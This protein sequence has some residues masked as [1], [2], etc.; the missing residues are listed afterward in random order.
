MTPEEAIQVA[1][2]LSLA[3]AGSQMT[4]IQRMILR[5][6]LEN[7][8]YDSMAD[9]AHIARQHIKNEGSQLWKL[10][11]EALGE[12]VS[13]KNFK[14]LLERRLR[15]GSILP[16]PPTSSTYN[17]QTWVGRES[18]INNLLPE[19][20]EQTRLLWITGISGIGKT[21]LGECLASQAWE[22]DPSFQ[23]IYLE[24][25]EGQSRDFPSIA[26]DLLG[27]LGDIELAP[28]ER[29]DPKRLCDRL[30]RKLQNNHYWVQLD[31]LERLINPDQPTEF[32]D[33]YWATFFRRCLTE[34]NF[35]SRLVLTAQA[36][37]TVLLSFCDDYAN[38]WQ[39]I[40]VNGLPKE[41]RLEFFAKRGVIVEDS[42]RE[43]LTRIAEIYEGHPL[44]LKVIAEDILKEFAGD[45]LNYWQENQ[46]EFEQVARE[47]QDARLD[48]TE[49]NEAL[50]R[51]VRERIR[52]S[53]EQLPGDALDLLCRSSVFRRPVPKQFW[54]AMISDRTPQQQKAAYRCLGD[55]ALVEQEGIHQNQHLIRQHNLIR[56]ITYDFLQQNSTT[57]ETAERRA[58]DQWLM[59]YQPPC[60]G[61]NLEKVR[62][63]LEAFDHLLAVQDWKQA[64][65]LAWTQI[66]TPTKEYLCCQ[67]GT[68]GYYREQIQLYIKLSK[69]YYQISDRQ[70]ESCTLGNLGVAFKNLGNSEQAIEHY[71]QSLVIDR[72]IN[73]QYGEAANLANLGNV[74]HILGKNQMAI[75]FQQQCLSIALGISDRVMEGNVLGSLG[76]AYGELHQHLYALTYHEQHLAITREMGDRQGEANALGSL[77]N[78]YYFLGKAQQAIT[79]HQQRLAIS[80]KIGDRRGEGNALSSLGMC[81]GELS[82]HLEAIDYHQ[83]HL[84]IAR[85]VGDQQGEGNALGNLGSMWAALER[86]A[87]AIEISQLAAKIFNAIGSWVSEAQICEHLAELYQYVGLIDLAQ[88]YCSRALILSTELDIPLKEECQRLATELEKKPED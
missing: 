10:L 2:E 46:R 58:A 45:V 28:M 62:G 13:K 82:Q 19:L 71:Q 55:R 54:L 74:Y 59:V 17:E 75:E 80:R 85:E 79:Y 11:A 78:T 37:P 63:Y 88:L 72:E 31:S 77:G 1:D 12:K 33:S 87:E 70:G 61:S 47:L 30:L 86:Y 32:L 56:D 22:S 9:E 8:T 39:Q 41:S 49:Y 44:V 68:W 5:E 60:N 35:I 4:D 52:Q 23:W 43:I 69:L 15:S 66:D 36:L 84:Q 76:L 40:Q 51:R 48:E 57:W 50:D 25:L 21:A 24:I 53:L 34:A 7:K 83:Q 6:S 29:N 14:G 67:L 73:N 81:C 18:L 65:T 64:I 42:N 26:A 16:K 27:K 38:T 3:H 20:Q